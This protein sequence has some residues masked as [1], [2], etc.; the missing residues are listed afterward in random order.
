MYTLTLS[1]HIILAVILVSLVLLQQGKGADAG[2]VMG[3]GASSLFGVGGAS[4]VL[5]RMTTLIAICFMLTSVALVRY[6]AIG[7]ST[8]GNR[9]DI[10]EGVD[11][12]ALGIT[13]VTPQVT[14]APSQEAA[15][16]QDAAPAVPSVVSPQ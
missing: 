4:S 13:A 12:E 11:F 2:A 3:G 7:S 9:A 10:T 15:P 16:K 8:L 1:V 5:V 6:A 14:T